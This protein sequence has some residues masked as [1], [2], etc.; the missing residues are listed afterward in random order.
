MV[1]TAKAGAI[2]V[3]ANAAPGGDGLTW[4]TAYKYLQDAFYKPPTSGDEIWVAE[5]TYKPDQDEGSNVTAGD[6]Y[7]TFELKDGVSFYGGFPIGGG[8]WEERDPNQYETTLSG[9]LNGDDGPDFVNNG[10]NSYCVVHYNQTGDGATLAGFTVTRGNANGSGAREAGGGGVNNESGGKL[11]L[12]NCT[13]EFN[14]ASGG[15]GGVFIYKGTGLSQI[16]NCIFRKN[17]TE[18]GAIGGGGLLLY[19]AG[20]PILNNCMFLENISG[21][22]GGL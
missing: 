17:K 2:F 15:G 18:P 10:E 16:F 11:V 5:G 22:G 1:C 20:S 13:L 8:T 4:G 6:R 9:D 12:I 14:S 3:D 21:D 7:A 19:R